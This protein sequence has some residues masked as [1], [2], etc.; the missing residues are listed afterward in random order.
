MPIFIP[1]TN[2][3]FGGGLGGPEVFV[4][5]PP[6]NMPPQTFPGQGM[7][8]GSTPQ[9]P[10]PNSVIPPQSPGA[11]GVEQG[12]G[13][14]SLPDFGGDY[15]NGIVDPPRPPA[16]P[17]M[18]P[19]NPPGGVTQAGPGN[20][21]G[22][23]A[24]ATMPEIGGAPFP[25]GVPPDGPGALPAR[26]P[27]PVGDYHGGDPNFSGGQAL[28]R[29]AAP[30][31]GLTPPTNVEQADPLG[32]D[33]WPGDLW[34]DPLFLD[35]GAPSTLEPYPLE[36][37]GT[38][39]GNPE[40]EFFVGPLPETPRGGKLPRGGFAL[41]GGVAGIPTFPNPGTM[42]PGGLPDLGIG[43]G[44][45]YYIHPTG[46][47]GSGFPPVLISPNPDLPFLPAPYF[48]PANPDSDL[49]HINPGEWPTPGGQYALPPPPKSPY[50]L[51]DRPPEYQQDYFYIFGGPDMGG[52]ADPATGG[53][54]I[55]AGGGTGGV[56]SKF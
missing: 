6:A 36:T 32:L 8:G 16:P 9:P 2:L 38:G 34:D 25:D 18:V 50:A 48:D 41:P 7:I 29:P 54:P 46:P 33:W 26:P 21:A 15:H 39:I 37:G 10:P 28:N 35:P 47:D 4:Q 31:S 51:G 45:L 17:T 43:K 12:G 5:I 13:G 27:Q 11:L 24:P 52:V 56:Q 30:P 55:G 53:L 19:S 23:P 20:A 22:V 44:G 14:T 49:P 3:I 40:S 1:D 42:Y